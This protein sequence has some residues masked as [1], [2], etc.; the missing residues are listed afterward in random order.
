MNVGLDESMIVILSVLISSQLY[1]D[2]FDYLD[3][4]ITKIDDGGQVLY[5]A[6]ASLLTSY[7][8][9]FLLSDCLG[10]L[11]LLQTPHAA[12]ILF[13]DVTP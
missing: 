9:C 7:R 11:L 6:E 3:Q 1:Q 2:V 8:H 13:D 12:A 10:F 5:P 4:M